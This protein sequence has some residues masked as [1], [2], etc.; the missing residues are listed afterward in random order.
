MLTSLIAIISHRR[1]EGEKLQSEELQAPA[2]NTGSRGLYSSLYQ[3]KPPYKKLQ[4]LAD[5]TENWAPFIENS[6]LTIFTDPKAKRSENV[7]NN[8]YKGN[9]FYFK[10]L[11][12]ISHIC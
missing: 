2:L 7:P 9:V 1:A 10:L 12:K 5:F 11:Y 3:E 8:Q 6:I 4:F